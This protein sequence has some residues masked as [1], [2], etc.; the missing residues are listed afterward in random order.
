MFSVLCSIIYQY[1]IALHD[2]LLFTLPY[3]HTRIHTYP[4]YQ[5]IALLIVNIITRT[6]S[7]IL[8]STH[9]VVVLN[10][11]LIYMYQY[12]IITVYQYV[13]GAMLNFGP[14]CLNFWPR[15]SIYRAYLRPRSAHDQALPRPAP[16]APAARPDLGREGLV[17]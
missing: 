2:T 15:S 12:T 13:F 6:H 10:G 16:P 8:T 4:T 3:Y 14:R 7:G 9:D 1:I 17:G 5:H 11:L